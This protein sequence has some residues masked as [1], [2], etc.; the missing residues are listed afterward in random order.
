MS[1]VT[2][3]VGFSRADGRGTSNRWRGSSWLAVI[4]LSSVGCAATAGDESTGTLASEIVAGSAVTPA[5]VAG[6]GVVQINH[7]GALCTGTI[8]R[9]GWVLT[10]GHCYSGTV[11]YANAPITWVNPSGVVE[12]RYGTAHYVMSVPCGNTTCGEGTLIP[13]ASPF[14]IQNGTNSDAPFVRNITPST[15]ESLVGQTVTC[16][17]FGVDSCSGTGAGTLRS[18][19]FQISGLYQWPQ[20]PAAGVNDFLMISA[21]AAGQLPLNGDSG[22]TCFMGSV[23]SGYATGVLA[24]AGCGWGAM[25]SG[26]RT[27]HD[28]IID[29]MG[30]QNSTKALYALSGTTLNGYWHTG[31]QNFSYSWRQAAVG[32][33]WN[34]RDVT[35][36]GSV[37]YAVDSSGALRWY[38]HDGQSDVLPTWGP[39]TGVQVNSGFAARHVIAGGDGVLYTVDASGLFRWYRH[40]ARNVGKFENIR[41]GE[42]EWASGSG[43]VIAGGGHFYTHITSPGDGVFYLRNSAGAVFWTRYSNHASGAYGGFSP[44]VFVRYVHNAVDMVARRGG[45]F[46]FSNTSGQLMESRH[47]GWQTGAAEWQQPG[48]NNT[49][50]AAADAQVGTGWAGV[51]LLG[52][53]RATSP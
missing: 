1:E 45:Y 32:T 2:S 20:P 3:G 13:L 42:A 8:I 49:V 51:R 46:Y 38:R 44:F 33:G 19:V 50:S 21:N 30:A 14:S 39:R 7:A 6:L 37:L 9:P 23:A 25:Y 15:H 5:S 52:S 31:Q 10:A 4:A 40:E 18:G 22:S 47:L 34:F 35:H 27:F 17:G 41:V 11:D 24:Q 16:L 53:S 43:N 48:T 28:G 26:P 29:R 36:D 12:T